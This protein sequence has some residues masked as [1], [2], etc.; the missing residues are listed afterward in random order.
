MAEGQERSVQL[1]ISA[2]SSEALREFE[3]VKSAA[4]QAAGDVAG[5]G[6]G[7]AGPAT[8]RARESTERYAL[9]VRDAAGTVRLLGTSLLSELNPALGSGASVAFDAARNLKD[10]GV[11]FAAAGGAA[12][13]ASLA[14]AAFV[15]RVREANE[16]QIARAQAVSRGD[17]GA[18]E[19]MASAGADAMVRFAEQGRLAAQP[20]T[21]ILSAGQAIVAFWEREFGPSIDRINDEQLQTLRALNEAFKAISLPRLTLQAQLDDVKLAER[22][23]DLERQTVTTREGARAATDAFI[24]LKQKEAQATRDLILTEKA[25]IEAQLKRGAITPF[26][27][28]ERSRDVER[29]GQR[30]LDAA[31]L[32]IEQALRQEMQQQ[33]AIGGSERARLSV[34]AATDSALA[35]F[36]GKDAARQGE[37]ARAALRADQQILDSGRAL[38]HARSQLLDLTAADEAQATAGRL[39]RTLP[40]IEADRTYFAERRRLIDEDTALAVRAVEEQAQARLRAG[41]IELEALQ[42]QARSVRAEPLFSTDLGLQGQ[43]QQLESQARQ[44]EARLTDIAR[45]GAAERARVEEIGIQQRRQAREQELREALATLRQAMADERAERDKARA[46]AQG[47]LGE[48][49]AS[50]QARGIPFGSRELLDAEAKR[51]LESKQQQL[52]ALEGGGAPID[53]AKLPGV[54]GSLEQI[55]RFQAG[56]IDLRN[57]AGIAT[58]GPGGRPGPEVTAARSR[59]EEIMASLGTELAGGAKSA[60]DVVVESLG[61]EGEKRFTVLG[62]IYAK[63]L[64]EGFAADPETV[65]TAADAVSRDIARMLLERAERSG[66]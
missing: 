59:L 44:I 63:K 8:D 17:A 52:T 18:L 2:D 9:S 46:E 36:A 26:I 34:A 24:Q 37:R 42:Q 14:I 43:A 5:A 58:Q 1:L 16:A 48:A 54:L 13:I 29:R 6:A 47:L 49:A 50:L 39:S 62:K 33:A 10:L 51:L 55:K 21:G 41:Q 25:Q 56:Q 19:G 35:E 23:L 22:R 15:S 3:R 32:E 65:R 38:A 7:A 28:G 40:T 12:A 57:L 31:A 20:L 45:Q 66:F 64:W 61:P 4:K 30:A 27:A 53:F 11:G 60:L